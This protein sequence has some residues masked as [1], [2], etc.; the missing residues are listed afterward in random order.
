MQN[1]SFLYEEEC[2]QI[3]VACYEVQNELGHVFLEAVY[4]E[5]LSI[6]FNEKGIPFESEKKLDIW[7]H[8]RK[9]QKAYYADFICFG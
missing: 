5:A 2:R 3:I 4:K 7:F 8:N 1:G 6:V 9:L